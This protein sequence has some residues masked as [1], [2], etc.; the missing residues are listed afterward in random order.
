MPLDRLMCVM[1]LV[2]KKFFFFFNYQSAGIPPHFAPRLYLAYSVR[3]TSR[4]AIAQVGSSIDLSQWNRMFEIIQDSVNNLSEAF[5]CFRISYSK[6]NFLLREGLLI[7]F[8]QMY[9]P[10][11]YNFLPL[12]VR[13]GLKASSQWRIS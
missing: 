4:I 1:F 9:C 5:W 10:N 7:I 11:I 2:G 13:G 8:C 6:K 3:I 12:S